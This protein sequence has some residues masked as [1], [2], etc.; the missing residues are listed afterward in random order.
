MRFAAFFRN[1][2]GQVR[3]G[4]RLAIWFASVFAVLFLMR[5]SAARLPQSSHQAFLDPVRLISDDLFTLVPV[6]VAT[7]VMMRIERR[8]S[9]PA[10]QNRAGRRPVWRDYY[11]P[12][13]DFFGRTFW[14]GL[15]WGFA[16]ISLDI[17]LIAAFGGYRI[18]GFATAGAELAKSTALWVVAAMVVGIVEEFFFRAYQLRTLADGIGFWPAA[19][20]NSLAFGALHYFQKPYER[21]EDWASV[22]LLGLFLCLTVRR[23]GTLAFAIGWHAAFDWGAMFFWS[24]RNAGE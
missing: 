5:F 1:S 20:I 11:W 10:D 6:L 21:W 7:L 13:Y 15:V 12:T 19:V 18:A 17:G 16:A 22:S 9:A 3:A 2:S 8:N 14:A 4:W 23:T 24:G